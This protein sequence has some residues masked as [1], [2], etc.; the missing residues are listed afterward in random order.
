MLH[1]SPF[2]ESTET[3]L[4][5][6]LYFCTSQVQPNVKDFRFENLDTLDCDPTL[7]LVDNYGIGLNYL[8]SA[9]FSAQYGLGVN[10]GLSQESLS[11]RP[12]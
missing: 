2:E 10:A 7:N 11:M 1:S 4:N 9:L 8:F 12:H 6:S 3:W 5:P